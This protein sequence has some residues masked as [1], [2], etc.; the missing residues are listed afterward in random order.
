MSI[1]EAKVAIDRVIKI[2]RIHLYKPI[3]IAEILYRARSQRDIDMADLETY[4]NPSKQ[5]RDLISLRLVGNVST[6]SQRYQ[7]NLFEENAIPPRL[8]VELNIANIEGNG[9]VE[10]YIYHRCKERWSLLIDSNQYLEEST[11]ESFQLKELVS[12]FVQEPGLKRSIDKIYEIVVYA[13]FITIVKE[14]RASVS[15]ELENPNPEIMADFNDFISMVLGITSDQTRISV[16]ANL[17]R[18]GVANAAD[19]GIDILTNF[20]PIVQVKHIS[21]T[22]EIVED[23]TDKVSAERIVI[24]CR[25]D[26]K[27]QIHSVLNQIG[28]R[29][30]IQGIITLNDLIHWYEICLSK[31]QNSMGN[32]LIESLR[33]E[34]AREFP[35][36][37]EIDAFF[38][39]RDYSSYQ[40]EDEW[41]II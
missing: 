7:D 38:N 34:Y 33:R 13:L 35:L 25:D 28:W 37:I 17:Y 10:N 30:R 19:L 29:E 23:I 11:P 16:P 31:Y 32:I 41:A 4:R 5:W 24:V 40:L 21:L 8:L 12:R 2:G 22:R 36:V 26:E 27:Y 9:T 6:S 15:L 20:G 39:E 18:A 14:L 1:A 3:Q